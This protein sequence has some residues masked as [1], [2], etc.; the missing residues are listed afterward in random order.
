MSTLIY[1]FFSFLSSCHFLAYRKQSSSFELD[2]TVTMSFLGRPPSYPTPTNH[3]TK[4][5]KNQSTLEQTQACCLCF[6]HSS[7]FI[8][9]FSLKKP[10][11]LFQRRK[12]MHFA[13][14]CSF[15]LPLPW[16][17]LSLVSPSTFSRSAVIWFFT[18]STAPA[19]SYR[20][21][22]CS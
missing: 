14:I 4:L 10:N 6:F 16:Q 3:D 19:V 20:L 13:W 5:L 22:F 11:Q 1:I 17:F 15:L 12:S 7:L 8:L 21:S 2:S 18:T 9:G